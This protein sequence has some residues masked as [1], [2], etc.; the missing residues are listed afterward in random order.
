MSKLFYDH[1]I[2]LGDLDREIG[3]SVGGE[4]EKHE[5]WKLVDEIIH[6]K[7]MGIILDKLPRDSHEEFA[8]LVTKFPHDEERIFDYLKKKIDKNI[9]EVLREELGTLSYEILNEAKKSKTK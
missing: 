3:N 6:H 4:E 7:V 2:V 1:L 8:D 9:E 5:L